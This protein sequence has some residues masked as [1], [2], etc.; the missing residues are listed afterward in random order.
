[1][2]SNRHRRQDHYDYVFSSSFCSFSSSF[3]QYKSG[4]LAFSR[5]CPGSFFAFPPQFC[6]VRSEDL[7]A[8]FVEC[9]L[10]VQLLRRI[11]IPVHNLKHSTLISRKNCRFFWVKTRENAVVLDFLVVDNFNFTRKIDAR[12]KVPSKC[13]KGCVNS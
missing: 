8:I 13:L 10:D 7:L 12:A 3:F 6:V 11:W 2:R 4:F 5:D 1:M 9:R